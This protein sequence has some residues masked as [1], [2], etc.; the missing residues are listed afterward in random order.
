[1][2]VMKCRNE[3]EEEGRDMRVNRVETGS[4]NT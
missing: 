2:I 4:K 1:M 3:W